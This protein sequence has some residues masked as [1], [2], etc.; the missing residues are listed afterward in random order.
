MRIYAYIR[1][2]EGVAQSEHNTGLGP[3][4]M[5]RVR[6]YLRDFRLPPQFK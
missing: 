1:S 2:T 5:N 6:F 4:T 3:V